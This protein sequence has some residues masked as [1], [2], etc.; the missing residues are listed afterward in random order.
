MICKSSFDDKFDFSP[1]R[2]INDTNVENKNDTFLDLSQR[3]SYKHDNN[4]HK[5]L[6][7]YDIPEI[8]SE[9]LFQSDSLL[10]N[11]EKSDQSL[12][13]DSESM[14]ISLIS[15]ENDL[16]LYKGNG[17]IEEF[18]LIQKNAKKSKI[19]AK[20]QIIDYFH[21]LIRNEIKIPYSPSKDELFDFIE[22]YS[23]Q[24]YA[25]NHF[26]KQNSVLFFGF[27]TIDELTTFSNKPQ[28]KPLLEKVPITKKSIVVQLSTLILTFIGVLDDNINKD[29][30]L[31]SII[32]I[33][34]DDDSLIDEFFMQL[35]KTMRNSPSYEALL[36]SWK[37]FLTV[38]ALFF[39][40]DNEVSN[41]IRWFL[42]HNIF[43][44]DIIGE[45][46][47]YAFILFYE[48]SIIGRNFDSSMQKQDILNISR[49]FLKG[50]EMFK[51][52][53]YAQMWNQKR[54]Y[55]N[56]PI[57]LTLYLVVKN[58]IKNGVIMTKNPFPDLGVNTKNSSHISS[59]CRKS[60]KIRN[61]F[62]KIDNENVIKD[63]RHNKKTINIKNDENSNRNVIGYKKD[64][65][66]AHDENLNRNAIQNQML[67]KK[68]IDDNTNQK[69]P[70]GTKTVIKKHYQIDNKINEND[71]I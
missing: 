62:R 50:N 54:E 47:N 56:L 24:N 27:Q 11:K 40:K 37:L 60:K 68:T 42:I 48:R 58:L 49:S 2:S 23:I 41:V 71:E 3:F 52:S 67:Y 30:L 15:F 26:R 5:T 46:A 44:E 64:H 53:L 4:N 55:P 14:N 61:D 31:I 36:L 16:N 19:I 22:P 32:S 1:Y 63:T 59:S 69:I 45:Y 51:C 57:P 25:S 33:L 21:D 20:I 38:S 6:N 9:I 8:D 43:E 35:I 66:R 13:L 34:H 7:I 17:S 70:K 29:N 39:V 18:N 10:E 28:S 65:K 12:S